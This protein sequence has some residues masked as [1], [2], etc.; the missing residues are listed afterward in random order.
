[1]L[2][3]G[4]LIAII[5]QSAMGAYAGGPAYVAGAS[6]FDSSTMGSPLSWAQGPLDYYTDQGNLSAILPGASADTF[7]ANALG[8]WTSI[9]TAAVSA[10]QA[11]HL[12]ENVSGLNLAAVNGII[13]TPADI[14]PSAT[15]TPIGIVYDEDGSVTD[16]LLGAGAS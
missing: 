10:V 4:V 3:S 2:R 12:A 8:M 15:S 11:G 16:A 13:T 6:Y 9:P 7:V 1:M 14:T 5:L